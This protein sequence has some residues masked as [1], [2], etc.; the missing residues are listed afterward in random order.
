MSRDITSGLEIKSV[1]PPRFKLT[2]EPW[3]GPT[4]CLIEFTINCFLYL[5]HP[6]YQSF[7]ILFLSFLPSS[8]NQF[9]VFF[10]FPCTCVEIVRL[11]WIFHTKILTWINRTIVIV[12]TIFHKWTKEGG[13]VNTSE[14]VPW[15]MK[16]Q[17]LM[18]TT[19][20]RSR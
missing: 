15:I 4:S 6:K 5:Y 14:R 18:N 19:L 7:P 8:V 1:S 16:T 13:D 12:E 2:L 20:E 11:F 17:E 3:I 10:L 9:I